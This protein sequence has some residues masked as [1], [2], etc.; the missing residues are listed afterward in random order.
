MAAD[1]KDAFREYG[2]I[3]TLV[4]LLDTHK[5]PEIA[6]ALT[7]VLQGNGNCPKASFFNVP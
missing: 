2:G 5:S 3:D 4:N 6:K 1:N 7:H